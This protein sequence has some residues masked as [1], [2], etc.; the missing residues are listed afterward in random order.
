MNSAHACQ[1]Q[2]S[3][4]ELS[5]EQ[6]LWESRTLLQIDPLQR[7]SL[8]I[9]PIPCLACIQL[10][11]D[12]ASPIYLHPLFNRPGTPWQVIVHVIRHELL[13]L[14]H[15][16]RCIDGTRM[17]H[18]PEFRRAELELVPWARS[19]VSWIWLNFHGVIKVS[20]SEER[21]LVKRS[22]KRHMDKP[23]LSWSTALSLSRTTVP[24]GAR[25]QRELL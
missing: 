20:R 19:S 18:T 4:L 6:L 2:L 3:F 15:R 10:Q 16:P 22:W 14:R 8:S 12:G 13:H 5:L 24:S 17:I 11:D 9:Q 1:P 25:E 21:I 23:L 7:I